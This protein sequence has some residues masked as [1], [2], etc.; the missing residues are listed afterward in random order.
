MTKTRTQLVN[1][2]TNIQ[3]MKEAYAFKEK[4]IIGLSNQTEYDRT[5]R[6]YD[7]LM[8][9][10]AKKI[11]KLPIGYRYTGTYYLKKPYTMPPEFEKR[12]GSLYMRENLVSWQ[13]E[14]EPGVCEYSYHRTVSKRPYGESI[15]RED[16]KPVGSSSFLVDLIMHKFRI[17]VNPKIIAEKTSQFSESHSIVF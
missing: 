11:Q 2:L 7:D 4:D 3:Y 17:P 9:T 8:K 6:H 5:I 12:E 16:A 14:T 15:T 13:I 1:L 10:L